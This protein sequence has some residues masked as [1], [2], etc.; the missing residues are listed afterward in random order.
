MSGKI[1]CPKT[2]SAPCIFNYS[3]VSSG[4]PDGW[5]PP[6]AVMDF[7]VQNEPTEQF[8]SS[9]FTCENETLRLYN[10]TADPF[11]KI[12]IAKDNSKIV[13]DLMERLEK[14]LKSMISPNIKDEIEEGNPNNFGGFWSPGWC[15]SEPQEVDP[16]IITID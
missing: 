4:R 1:A 16:V 9:A 15:Q 6:P 7:D 12:N 3:L 14:Y 5:V 2:Y 11:E 13:K 8:V 10:L